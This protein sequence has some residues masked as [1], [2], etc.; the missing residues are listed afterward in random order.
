MSRKVQITFQATA[1]AGWDPDGYS[2]VTSA[3][4]WTE[5]GR[6]L[7]A[8]T[9][10]HSAPDAEA[11]GSMSYEVLVEHIVADRVGF[12]YRR[13]VIDNPDGTIDLG[14]PNSGQ[15]ILRLGE[16]KKLS[17]PTMDAGTSVLVTLNDITSTF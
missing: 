7:N 4:L 14:A 10:G 2:I 8:E 6:A 3:K 9:L 16:T 1:W 5:K 12:A 15:F 11:T 13:L 17:T